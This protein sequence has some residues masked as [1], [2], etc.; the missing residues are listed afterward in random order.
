MSA[1]VMPLKTNV[2]VH[3]A[4]LVKR[5]KEQQFHGLMGRSTGITQ[6]ARLGGRRNK[7]EIFVGLMGRRSPSKDFQEERDRPQLYSL[8]N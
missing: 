2:L 8:C 3:F 6:P 5:T 1:L 7:G 4:D